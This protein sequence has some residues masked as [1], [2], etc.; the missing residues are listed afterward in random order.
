MR[1]NIYEDNPPP[2]V[3]V[4]EKINTIISKVCLDDKI[5][6]KLGMTQCVIR[7]RGFL[8]FY[9]IMLPLCDTPLSGIR[10][11]K[12]FPYYSKVDKW[13]NLYAY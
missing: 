11:S 10:E 13:Y 12:R 6:K 8:F 4:Q 9:Q 5:L 3:D 7:E 1:E 2:W